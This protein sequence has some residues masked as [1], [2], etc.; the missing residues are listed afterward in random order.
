M[1]LDVEFDD[2]AQMTPIEEFG[3][4]PINSNGDPETS[5][6][7]SRVS[8]ISHPVQNQF[9]VK[10]KSK[11]KINWPI[12]SNNSDAGRAEHQWVECAI[13]EGGNVVYHRSDDYE[14]PGPDDTFSPRPDGYVAEVETPTAADGVPGDSELEAGNPRQLEPDPI[15]KAM[16]PTAD[17]VEAIGKATVSIR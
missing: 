15:H 10:G 16:E 11:G 17:D 7:E 4:A 3:S 1:R 14:A 6:Y 2:S 12:G 13:Y 9:G 8:G 5:P